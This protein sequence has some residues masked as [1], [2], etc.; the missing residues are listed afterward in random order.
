MKQLLFAMAVAAGTGVAARRQPPCSE[1][2]WFRT[3]ARLAWSTDADC[4]A[5]HAAYDPAGDSDVHHAVP[6][7]HRVLHFLRQALGT[8]STPSNK[9]CGTGVFLS[10]I[11]VQPVAPRCTSK[12]GSRSKRPHLI[13]GGWDRAAV[14]IKTFLLRFAR[15][16]DIQLLWSS[17]TRPLR[18]LRRCAGH[19]S[20]ARVRASELK[21]AFQIGAVLFFRF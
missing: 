5:A 19:R 20:D 6:A 2:R 17:R 18:R 13:H 10:L 21:A 3:R 8:Q 9:C 4:L 12:A 16:K 14:P 7:N 11:V 15:E 1:S